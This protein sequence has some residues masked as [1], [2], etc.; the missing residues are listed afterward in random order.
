MFE[1][2]GLGCKGR[3][4]FKMNAY[5]KNSAGVHLNLRYAVAN[6]NENDLIA[7]TLSDT[8]D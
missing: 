1:A 5:A 7:V 6:L 4:T 8:Y 3:T 2:L